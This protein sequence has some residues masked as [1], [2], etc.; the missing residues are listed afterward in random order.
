MTRWIHGQPALI[1]WSEK[2]DPLI[3]KFGN[4]SV[5]FNSF[6][7]LS[8]YVSCAHSTLRH[9]SFVRTMSKPHAS[10]VDFS[11]WHIRIRSTPLYG[12]PWLTQF[13]GVSKAIDLILVLPI[14]QL[15]GLAASHL[16]VE[17]SPPE[18]MD[19]ELFIDHACTHVVVTHPVIGSLSTRNVLVLY[20]C[21]SGKLKSMVGII[22]WTCFSA[23][24]YRCLGLQSA[25]RTP[26]RGA[27]LITYIFAFNSGSSCPH[28]GLLAALK[29]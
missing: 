23:M 11:I 7:S 27:I 4:S 5:S 28:S 13:Y 24:A 10:S 20:S 16:G 29:L 26:E 6:E 9:L 12:L 22:L 3:N 19:C 25:G 17:S 8:L 1:F 2:F 15:S 18:W 14:Y 21:I